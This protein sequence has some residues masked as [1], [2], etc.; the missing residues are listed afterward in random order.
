M[1]ATIT[2]IRCIISTRAECGGKFGFI[3]SSD[4]K[5]LN[6]LQEKKCIMLLYVHH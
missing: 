3:A 6:K 4:I 2:V 5:L 1:S